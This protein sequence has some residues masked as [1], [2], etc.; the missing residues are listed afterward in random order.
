MN[1]FMLAIGG[2][3]RASSR[4]RVWDHVEA[5]AAKGYEVQV[6]SVVGRG[7]AANDLRFFV[8]LVRLLPTWVRGFFAADAIVLQETMLLWPLLPLRNL[9]KRRRVVFDFSDP[10]DRVGSRRWA[11]AIRRR[12][13]RFVTLHVDAVVVENGAYERILKPQGIIV[14]QFYGP[15]DVER[16]EAARARGGTRPD[17]PFRIG[18]TGSPG[19]FRFI[20]PLLAPIDALAQT[21]PVE[22]ILIG[23]DGIDADMR[24][25]SVTFVPWT[26]AGEFAEVPTFDL[27]LFRVDESE[28]ALW[29]G[30]GKLF[31]YLASSVPFIATNR[32]IARDVMRES[33]LGFPVDSEDSWLDRLREAVERTDMRQEFGARSLSYARAHL[34]YER[35]RDELLSLLYPSDDGRGRQ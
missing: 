32:G 20:A 19:T 9:G 17:G 16:F 10:V 25:A 14:R 21:T 18:W 13:L 23:V 26:E 27:G 6:D 24:H 8:R 11:R 35:Y 4:L 33:G 1:I 28:D 5:L 29:R 12:L 2:R 34:S 31:I 15:A 22:L 3:E 30:A 7:L